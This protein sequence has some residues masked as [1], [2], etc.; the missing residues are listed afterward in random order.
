[1]TK[2]TLL[3]DMEETT[4]QLLTVLS[5][6][7]PEQ[8]NERP[9]ETEWSAA[10]VAEHLLKADVSTGN[11]LSGETVPTNRPPDE[12]L[13]MIQQAM[14]DDNAKRV[15][16]ER[17]H[18]SGEQ[19]EA[20]AILEQIKKQKEVLKEAILHSDITEA[21]T[22]FKHPVLGTMTKMEWMTFNMRHT[23]RHLRQLK[24]LQ[25]KLSR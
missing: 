16:P 6:F 20:A 10:Q 25:E 8:F 11:A 9:S 5:S 21:C 1:M 2:E 14:N 24:R 4:R 15:A 22:S 23:E 17:V 18:P 13:A 19:W 3:S 12:K 7:T